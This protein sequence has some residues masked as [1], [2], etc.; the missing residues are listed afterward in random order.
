MTKHCESLAIIHQWNL[1][2]RS[3]QCKVRKGTKQIIYFILA[4]P[5]FHLFTQ[6]LQ[7]A[8]F[9]ANKRIF[10]NNKNDG[11]PSLCFDSMEKS[12]CNHLNE[13]DIVVMCA[14]RFRQFSSINSNML[15]D[16]YRWA[17]TCSSMEFLCSSVENVEW[18]GSLILFY[19]LWNWNKDACNNNFNITIC[20]VK[21][22]KYTT[23]LLGTRA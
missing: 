2:P 3:T 19:F 10:L 11:F 5:F 15:D 17:Y 21:N 18:N 1:R 13:V 16:W 22:G 8:L 7:I 23:K 9:F 6:S 20:S 12:Q 4:L 14:K